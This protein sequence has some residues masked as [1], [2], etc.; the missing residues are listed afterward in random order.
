MQMG[1][2]KVKIKANQG[3]K[4]ANDGKV[5][6]VHSYNRE[7]QRLGKPKVKIK[8]NTETV[9]GEDEQKV[10]EIDTH[11]CTSGKTHKRGKPKV[12]IKQA[13]GLWMGK[14]KVKMKKLKLKDKST[15]KH[16]D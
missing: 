14:P 12:K 4:D 9:N 6:V 13:R 1:K 5:I 3:Q 15:D 7:I 8:V 11:S 16:L 2:P 10:E